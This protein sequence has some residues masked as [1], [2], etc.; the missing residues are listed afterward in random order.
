MNGIGFCLG[1]AYEFT[2][3]SGAPA[4]ARTLPTGNPGFVGLLPTCTN[5]KP[6]CIANITQQADA[7]AKNGYDAV[8]TIQIPD[9]GDPWGG[10]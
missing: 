1:A 9:S 4:P 7:K 8:M 3:R 10:G 5:A 6:P 2:T